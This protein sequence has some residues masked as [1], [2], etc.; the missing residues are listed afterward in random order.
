MKEECEAR[1]RRL[2]TANERVLAV[3]TADEFK[4]PRGDLGV[5][6]RFRFL[7]V[8]NGRLLFANW[9]RP[10][11]SHEEIRWD[12]V[13]GWAD[14]TQYHRYVMTLRHP[15]MTRL[16][17]ETAHKFLWIQWGTSLRPHTRSTTTL[18]FSQRHTDAANALRAQLEEIAIP[19]RKILLEEPS[20]SER[21]ARSH[22]LTR[23]TRT[24]RKKG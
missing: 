3:G 9:A 12:D 22:A 24:H 23:P 6:G 18:R 15:P 1:L 21:T 2:V 7:V 20:R 10:R 14:G 16:E 5:Q 17:K 4:E 8:T 13:T 19:H 11:A